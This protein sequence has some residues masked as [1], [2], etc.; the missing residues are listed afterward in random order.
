MSAIEKKQH[1]QEIVYK[2]YFDKVY[3]T[4]KSMYKMLDIY[5]F[6]EGYRRFRRLKN[7]QKLKN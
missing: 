2:K 6:N 5:N 7:T 3:K 4:T 1:L